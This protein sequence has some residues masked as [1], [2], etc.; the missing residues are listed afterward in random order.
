MD[1]RNRDHAMAQAITYWPLTVETKAQSQASPHVCFVLGKV[2][3]H[4]VS[5]GVLQSSPPPI[6]FISPM[7]CKH[8][9]ILC[10]CYVISSNGSIV[11]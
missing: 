8:S 2:P 7:H 1:Y 3:M 4:E 5:L 11:K 6:I 9:F 10:R